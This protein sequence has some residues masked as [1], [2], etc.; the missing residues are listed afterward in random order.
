MSGEEVVRYPICEGCLVNGGGVSSGLLKFTQVRKIVN[1]DH[2]IIQSNPVRPGQLRPRTI[3][4]S[5]EHALRMKPNQRDKK[6]AKDAQQAMS[7][8]RK[9]H[10]SFGKEK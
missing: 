10:L 9:L 5:R 7:L 4:T 2:V 3:E 8:T 1:R 6:A